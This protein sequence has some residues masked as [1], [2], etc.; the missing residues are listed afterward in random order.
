MPI[1]MEE[2][3]IN[4]TAHHDAQGITKDLPDSILKYGKRTPANNT[5]RMKESTP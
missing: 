1:T 4:G 3:T 5:P 2:T